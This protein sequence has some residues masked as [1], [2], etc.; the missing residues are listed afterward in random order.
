MH[1]ENVNNPVV[2][3]CADNLSGSNVSKAKLVSVYVILDV[4]MITHT[5]SSCVWGLAL[6]TSDKC[7][8]VFSHCSRCYYKSLEKPFFFPVTHT[9][10]CVWKYF[11][12]CLWCS[13]PDDAVYLFVVNHPQ[14]KSQVE[15][16]KFAEEDFSLLHLKTI[17]H[18][19]LHRYS[20]IFKLYLPWTIA[21]CCDIFTSKPIYIEI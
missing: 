17:T 11:L 9:L 8:P 14:H 10:V 5:I 6:G 7:R 15:L 3:T 4:D 12:Q 18:E 16:F 20:D 13:S 1:V 21:P 19:L 2:I